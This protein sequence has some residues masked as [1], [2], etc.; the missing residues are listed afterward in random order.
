MGT[1]ESFNTPT[2][3]HVL[4][5]GARFGDTCQCVWEWKTIDENEL[6]SA[7]FA[8]QQGARSLSTFWYQR[9]D[10]ASPSEWCPKFA[11]SERWNMGACQTHP[12]CIYR[13]RRRR[14]WGEFFISLVQDIC[15]LVLKCDT[16]IVNQERTEK[17]FVSIVLNQRSYTIMK[18]NAIHR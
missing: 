6:L 17:R 5:P 14:C 15:V 12:R 16:Y 11:N 18:D 13:Q 2:E 8:G 1:A 10:T 4:E 9:N 3:L 7:L